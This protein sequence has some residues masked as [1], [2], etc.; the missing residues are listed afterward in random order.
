[1]DKPTN[2]PIQNKGRIVSVKLDSEQQTKLEQE[3]AE[4]GCTMSEL[5]RYK[6][7]EKKAETSKAIPPAPA[8]S[9][10]PQ[11]ANL[12]DEALLNIASMVSIAV[13]GSLPQSIEVSTPVEQNPE[14]EYLRKISGLEPEEETTL[15]DEEETYLQNLK[16]SIEADLRTSLL[17]VENSIPYP[18]GG[19]L[20]QTK[21]FKDLLAKRE[22][23]SSE[24]TPSLTTI[25]QSAIGEAF[26]ADARRLY[27]SGLFRATYGFEYSEFKAVFEL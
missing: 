6:L 20:I 27:N 17:K 16:E 26:F 18:I 13:K 3:A 23:T 12:S 10:V 5:L 22:E 8:G 4:R 14:R 2:T 9:P 21:M 7:E 19:D 24:K 15:T 25:F 11:I 1:M